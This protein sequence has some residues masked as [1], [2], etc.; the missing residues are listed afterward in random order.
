MFE[1]GKTHTLAER[2][3]R[4]TRLRSACS[5][6]PLRPGGRDSADARV[7]RKTHGAHRTLMSVLFAMI[8]LSCRHAPHSAAVV[9]AVHSCRSQTGTTSASSPRDDGGEKAATPTVYAR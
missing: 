7:H 1:N 4:A 5:A 9:A 8:V 3:T 6:A 2:F